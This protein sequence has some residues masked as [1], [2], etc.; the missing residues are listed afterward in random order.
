MDWTATDKSRRPHTTT[1]DTKPEGENS[2]NV[3]VSQTT[4]IDE[5]KRNDERKIDG[6]QRLKKMSS[7]ASSS[8]SKLFVEV[9]PT[10]KYGRCSE[11]LDLTLSKKFNAILTKKKGLK[12]L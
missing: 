9:D 7:Y 2:S 6:G 11:L 5:T 12:S 10:G 8:D 3:V 4:E 1:E